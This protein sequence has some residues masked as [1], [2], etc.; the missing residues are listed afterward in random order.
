[1]ISDCWIS[2]PSLTSGSSHGG[3]MC[4]FMGY[5]N[6]TGAG[7]KSFDAFFAKFNSTCG[8]LDKH[9]GKIEGGKAI[10]KKE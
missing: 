2:L 5:K 9:F 4:L 10:F 7:F 6:V 1:M 8:K 3:H